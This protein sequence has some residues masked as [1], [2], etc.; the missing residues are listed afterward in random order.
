MIGTSEEFLLD[1]GV[2]KIVVFETTSKKLMNKTKLKV[3]VR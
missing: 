3:L 1:V 2:G